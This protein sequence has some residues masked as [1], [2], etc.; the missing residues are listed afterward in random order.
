MTRFRGVCA[1]RSRAFADVRGRPR[2]C[3][4]GR[5]DWAL[6]LSVSRACRHVRVY[7]RFAWQAWG[8]VVAC[9]RRWIEGWRFV[10]QA[11]R[12]RRGTPDARGRLGRRWAVDSRGRCGAEHVAARRGR[13]RVPQRFP[14]LQGADT[15]SRPT[16]QRRSIWHG[17]LA[18]LGRVVVKLRTEVSA[19]T[20]WRLNCIICYRWVLQMD[21]HRSSPGSEVLLGTT[22]HRCL[23]TAALFLNT[24]GSG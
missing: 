9:A 6:E 7:G 19:G 3:S 1:E 10:W 22:E 21:H 15:R 24:A 13:H 8:I 4:R 20:E 16:I 23:G 5:G 18:H 11:S 2:A 12:G 17:C 14:G